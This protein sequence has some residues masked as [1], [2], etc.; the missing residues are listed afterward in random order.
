[1]LALKCV[2]TCKYGKGPVW[3]LRLWYQFSFGLT[4]IVSDCESFL[5]ARRAWW[6]VIELWFLY[7]GVCIICLAICI[8]MIFLL[9]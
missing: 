5:A 6:R 9:L 4:I 2:I 3:G 7:V 8:G 1:M